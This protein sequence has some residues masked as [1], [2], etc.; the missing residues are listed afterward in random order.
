MV[1]RKKSRN[2]FDLG[3]ASN[4]INIG[5]TVIIFLIFL[6]FVEIIDLSQW[7]DLP[8]MSGLG[9]G[10][11]VI[12]NGIQDEYEPPEYL[13][14]SD[15]DFAYEFQKAMGADAFAVFAGG[16]NNVGGI[17]TAVRDEVGCYWNPAVH[18]LN[19]NSAAIGSI[20]VFCEGT[21]KGNWVCDNSIAYAGCLCRKGTPPVWGGEEDQESGDGEEDSITYCED[22]ELIGYGDHDTTCQEEGYCVGAPTYKCHHYWDWGLKEHHCA[23]TETFFCGQYCYEYWYTNE[24]ECPPNSWKQIITRSTFQCVPNGYVCVN[25]TPI[26]ED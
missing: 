18:T 3:D 14:C 24:C 8:T 17:F 11:V 5:I 26:F 19:C 21:L 4:L 20:E 2:G 13:Y 15:Y 25:G 16:C 9:F 7:I 22:V 1:K 23:C 12:E 10:Q 6:N